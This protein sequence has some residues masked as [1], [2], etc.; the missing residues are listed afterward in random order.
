M[1]PIQCTF[2]LCRFFGLSILTI[3]RINANLGNG[4]DTD[5]L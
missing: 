3:P 4:F 1:Y 5:A 2:S